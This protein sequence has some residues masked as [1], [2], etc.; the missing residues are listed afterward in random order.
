[1]RVVFFGTPAFAVPSLEAL[2][3]SG[4]CTVVAVVTQP[5]RP[6]TRS[7]ST[8][9]PSP[10][11]DVAVR[12][13]I[14]VWQPDRPRGDT[15]LA[16]L[17][18]AR[19]DLG[20]VVAYGHILRSEVLATPRLGML[21]VHASLLPRWRGAAPIHWAL[22]SGD[23]V[24]GV[25][26]MQMEAGLDSGPVWLARSTPIGDSET[27][28]EL[29]A[30]LATLGADALL[31]TLPLLGANARPSPQDESRVTLAPKVDRAIA[32]VRW[33]AT[34]REVSCRIRAMDPAPGAWA[35]WNGQPIKLF[36]P[37]VLHASSEGAA[38]GTIQ[39]GHEMLHVAC[40]DAWIG[41]HEVQP[42]GGR[43]MLAED[44]FRGAARPDRAAFA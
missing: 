38:P 44:W 14:P 10:V 16:A 9:L 27:T 29:L 3:A 25:S 42:A 18:D 7:H 8:L 37:I 31:E 4:N 32:R 40:G 22:L 1:M 41:I 24:T 11:K 6:R 30:R 17:R 5:D 33:D 2:R 28:G 34:A 26:L 43:R 35:E 15:F 20:V 36:R 39:A 19:A 21:N 23:E 12:A 13:G